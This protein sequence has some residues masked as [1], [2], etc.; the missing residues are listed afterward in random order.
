MIA[1]LEKLPARLVG[2]FA[3]AGFTVITLLAFTG[4]FRKPFEP[5]SHTVTAMFDRAAQVYP[6]DEVRIS[7]DIDGSVTK[8]TRSATANESEVTMKVDNSAG[9]IYADASA[10]TRIKT[11]LAGSFYIAIDRGTPGAGALGDKVIQRENTHTQVELEDVTDIFKEGALEGFKTLPTQTAAA[12]SDAPAIAGDLSTVDRIA[13]NAAVALDALRGQEKGTDLPRVVQATARAVK[14]IDTGN[15]DLRTLVSGAAATLQTTGN[16]AAEIRA[17]I[18]ASPSVAYDLTTTLHRLD[19][20]LDVADGLFDRLGP[21]APEL[22]PALVALEP[23]LDNTRGLLNAAV[24]VLRQAPALLD[25]LGSAARSAVPLVNGLRPALRK[26]DKTILPYF[27]AVDP[28]TGHTTTV[29]IGGTAAGFGGAGGQ[30]DAN[31]H[32]IRFPASAGLSSPSVYLPCKSSL[33][34]PD[35][36]SLLKCDQFND[37]VTNYLNY[38][39][40]L[41]GDN[42]VPPASQRKAKK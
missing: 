17:T 25:A 18:K 13:P 2:M 21:A 39:P 5:G 36:G 33:I 40:K 8:V 41:N 23:S 6:G 37:V 20:T 31:G 42:I 32:F 38:L 30:E 11:L 10:Q 35:A 1:R 14:A 15:D 26:V 9:P 12:F 34:D 24:P 7:G 4:I 28:E 3:L 29:M 22:A 27:G 19:H 16:R